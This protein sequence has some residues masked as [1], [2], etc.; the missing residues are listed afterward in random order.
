VGRRKKIALSTMVTT[1]TSD[2]Y[3]PGAFGQCPTPNAVAIA[4][5]SFGFAPAGLGLGAVS[6]DG[7][8]GIRQ[9]HQFFVIFVE[10]GLGHDIFFRRPVSQIPRA[11]PLA[12]KREVG[13]VRGIRRRFANRTTVLHHENSWAASSRSL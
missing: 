5:A 1:P 6:V 2:P 12:A 7:V 4:Y 10:N 9:I 13:V 11:A 8:I 3:V